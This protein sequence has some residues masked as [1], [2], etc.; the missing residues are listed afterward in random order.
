[1]AL[2]SDV[3]SYPQLSSYPEANPIC[4]L[5]QCSGGKGQPYYWPLGTKRPG[6]GR[7]GAA[8]P[9]CGPRSVSHSAYF[10]GN[11]EFRVEI[12]QQLPESPRIESFS[13]SRS[14]SLKSKCK[15]G[16]MQR[17]S[18]NTSTLHEIQTKKTLSLGRKH[19]AQTEK[20]R[21]G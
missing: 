11:S 19:A 18:V 8:V 10:R 15:K 12:C 21:L 1:L 14:L 6:V 13:K 5:R 3:T 17:A 20:L 9:T 7:R 16:Q 2:T 4:T